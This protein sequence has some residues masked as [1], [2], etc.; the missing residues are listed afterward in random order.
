[1]RRLELRRSSVAGFELV[2]RQL[3]APDAV[4][5]E[6]LTVAELTVFLYQASKTLGGWTGAAVETVAKLRRAVG[7]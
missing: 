6:Q 2:V 3:G 7:R 5:V 4:V 1:V